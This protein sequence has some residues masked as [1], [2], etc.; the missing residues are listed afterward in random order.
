MLSLM[1]GVLSYRSTTAILDLAGRAKNPTEGRIPSHREQIDV[2]G[3]QPR[4]S[5]Q[6]MP[7]RTFQ[8]K[9]RERSAAADPFLRQ[10]AQRQDVAGELRS[11]A[12]IQSVLL[13]RKEAT[14]PLYLQ[15][16]LASTPGS[17]HSP[18]L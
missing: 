2:L 3:N 8:V 16:F 17:P 15:P 14:R 13:T 11:A 5:K 6:R 1:I 9:A 18:P 4:P 10:T 7:A 12:R